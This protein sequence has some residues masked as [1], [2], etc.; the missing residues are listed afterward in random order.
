MNITISKYQS[1]F[2][3]IQISVIFY[4][5]YR[6]VISD[7]DGT[8]TKS[9]VRGMLLPLMGITDWAQGEV[10]PLFSKINANGYKILYL[11]ARF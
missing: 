11:S 7:I 9:D 2:I 4:H 5:V 10:A 8:I 3:R 1:T 6:V